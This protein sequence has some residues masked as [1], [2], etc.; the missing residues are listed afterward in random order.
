[1]CTGRADSLLRRGGGVSVHPQSQLPSPG[2]LPLTGNN[3][4]AQQSQHSASLHQPL[5][6]SCLPACLPA[7]DLPALQWEG[8]WTQQWRAC[9]LAY[10][11][12]PPDGNNPL[13][14]FSLRAVSN[15]IADGPATSRS[16]P[17]LLG[18]GKTMKPR[19]GYSC[20]HLILRLRGH[21][22]W[23]VVS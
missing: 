18:R 17:T 22:I 16:N 4:R 19:S 20:G 23:G 6:S 2:L 13:G 15:S 7:Q 21:L 5:H 8:F 12:S 11:L 10:L 3:S 9:L 14:R 1:M